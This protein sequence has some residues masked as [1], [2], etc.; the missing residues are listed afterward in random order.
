MTIR[1][2]IE[3]DWYED[4]RIANITTASN[5]IIVQDSHDTLATIED[6]EEGTQF[7]N[8]VS[9][10]GKES[11]GGGTEVGITTTLQNV[12]YA[13][14]RT[15]PRVTTTDTVTTGGT[16]S[17][18]CS[19][20]TFSSDGVI[21]GDWVLNWTDQ[22]I[23]EVLEVLSETE[24]R[25]RTP[26]GMAASSN[27]FAVSDVITIW[28]VS[29]FSLAGGNFVAID[30][31]DADINPLFPVFGRFI[32]K[33]SASSATIQNQEQL[34]AAAFNGGVAFDPTSIYTGTAFPNGTREFPSNNVADVQAISINRGLRDIFVMSNVSLT[35]T[36][37]MS[38]VAHRWIG[39][40]R[41]ISITVVGSNFDLSGNSFTLLTL[42]G[43]LGTGVS[44]TFCDVATATSFSGHVNNCSF[45]GETTLLGDTE[46]ADCVSGVVG[47]GN[48]DFVTATYDLQ[49]SNWHRSIGI[50]GMTAGTHT[51]E[52][53]GGRLHLDSGCTG[54]TV[55]ERGW[56][57]EVANDLSA[58]TTLLD[59]TGIV[60][61]WA[62]KKALSVLKFLTLQ[63]QK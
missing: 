3:I 19:A 27:D 51:I 30:D 35:G 36:F 31:V 49:V 33:A 50:K 34:E 8:L 42:A 11:L 2:D 44:L 57:S 45:N 7:P 40:N 12:Q 62:Y 15:G 24:L 32:S 38:T 54:G 53:Y 37:D 46:I 61:N 56:Y 10:A 29:E 4:P 43:L 18:I 59:E 21:R 17:F 20:A 23:T 60:S 55:H 25:V 13:P 22:S 1:T 9:S 58:G 48:P 16:S 14:Q 39:D 52:L 5:E 41:N 47:S 6:D 63:E 28:E 26:S